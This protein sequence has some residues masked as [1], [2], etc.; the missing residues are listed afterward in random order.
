MR[1]MG[2]AAIATAAVLGSTAVSLTTHAS[3]AHGGAV[4][5]R[6]RPA[7]RAARPSPSGGTGGSSTG[8]NG[9]LCGVLSG[10]ASNDLDNILGGQDRSCSTAPTC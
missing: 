7:A 8:G 9:I 3:K 6:S 10:I 4:R 5:P 2:I 1:I